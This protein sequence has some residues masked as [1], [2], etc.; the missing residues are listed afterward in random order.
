MLSTKDFYKKCTYNQDTKNQLWC[1]IIADSHDST[2]GCDRPFAHLLASIFP[3]GHADR[4]L[5]VNQILERDY[6][7]L[8]LSGGAEEENSGGV[9]EADIKEE[10]TI[11]QEDKEDADRLQGEDLENLLSAVADAEKR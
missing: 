9:E 3:P 2:C 4:N 8:C 1:S 6:K 7:S 10:N 11:K 5:T